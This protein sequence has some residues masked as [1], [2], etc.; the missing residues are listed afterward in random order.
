M[1]RR[2]TIF[3]AWRMGVTFEKVGDDMNRLTATTIL[4]IGA[5]LV[6][7]GQVNAADLPAATYKTPATVVSPAFNWSG[8]YLGANGGY[9]KSANSDGVQFTDFP[10]GSFANTFAVGQTPRAIGFT[11]K[12]VIGGAEAGYNWRI[13]AL[14]L[15]VEG[16]F[17]GANIKGSGTFAFTGPLILGAPET[18]TAGSSLG[19]LATVRG[20]IGFTPA[21][22]LLI[23]GTAGVAFGQV[24]NQSSFV[25]ANPP[26]FPAFLA[27]LNGSDKTTRTGWVAGAGA[28][29]AI[30]DNLFAKVEWLHYDLGTDTFSTPEVLNGVTQPFGL[31]S[32]FKTNGNIVRFGFDFRLGG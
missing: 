32:S 3:G 10:A 1:G 28:Q 16:D 22:R 31:N 11:P 23:F 2:V 21:D 9:G 25:A 8:F 14:V 29:Y 12:G 27:T 20:R 7:A 5:A 15:G 26:G 24:N 19:W 6:L 30:T 17:S 13:G 4:G 18:T